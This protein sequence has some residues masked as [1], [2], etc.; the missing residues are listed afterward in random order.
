MPRHRTPS[1]AVGPAPDESPATSSPPSSGSSQASV[2]SRAEHAT[3]ELRRLILS[4]ALRPGESLAE[5][6]LERLLQ[7]SRSPVREALAQLARE[8][9]VRRE[10]RGFRVA[11]V[12]VA[13]LQELFAFRTLL[14][15]T[16]VRWAAAAPEPALADVDAA[17]RELDGDPT[18]EQRLAATARLHLGLARASGNRFV[19][20]ALAALFPRVTRARYLE[21][22]SAR[23]VAQAEDEH[24][25]IVAQVRAGRGDDA[26]ETMR[27]HLERTRQNL[28]T[29]LQEQAGVRTMLGEALP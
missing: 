17:L 21:L 5:R 24:R 29:S 2:A 1:G 23:T 22:S 28:L 20:E 8:G 7:V 25:R 12:D 27:G 15:T 6:R 18:P 16:A 4:F 3:M 11:P 10:G 14:E 19:A 13:E 9:L 26:A